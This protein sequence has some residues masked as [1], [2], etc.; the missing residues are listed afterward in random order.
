V[1][2]DDGTTGTLLV[3]EPGQAELLVAF[4]PD[5]DL[6]VVQIDSLADVAIGPPSAN[7]TIMRARLAARPRW[8]STAPRLEFGTVTSTEFEWRK[9]H[10]SM[11]S[12][13]CY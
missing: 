7:S 3:L 10:P 4:P 12:H 9:S 5:P 11:K 1:V 6:V 2:I 13:Q 8:F